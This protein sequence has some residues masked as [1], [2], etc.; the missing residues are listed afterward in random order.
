MK[1]LSSLMNFSSWF[2]YKNTEVLTYF[3]E[4]AFRETMCHKNVT[5]FLCEAKM[6]QSLC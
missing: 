1:Y 3:I 4:A 5:D 2:E 6:F